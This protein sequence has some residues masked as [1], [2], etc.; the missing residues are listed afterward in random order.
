MTGTKIQR[1]TELERLV[2]EL[3][4]RV[5]YLELASNKN[6]IKTLSTQRAGKLPWGNSPLPF[7]K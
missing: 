7:S 2:R 3:L 6:A 5:K 4:E 1:I